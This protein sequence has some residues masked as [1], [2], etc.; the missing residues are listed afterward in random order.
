MVFVSER[1]LAAATETAEQLSLRSGSSESLTQAM[2][3]HLPELLHADLA[4]TMNVNLPFRSIDAFA[5]TPP[6][7]MES[8]D[9]EWVSKI[10]GQHPI[11]RHYASAPR[12]RPRL[13]SDFVDLK[14][15]TSTGIFDEV[16]RRLGTPYQLVIPL[17]LSKRDGTVRLLDLTRAKGDFSVRE[18]DLA[19]VLQGQLIA[20][21]RIAE[22]RGLSTAG[23]PLTSATQLSCDFGLTAREQEVV[24]LL[25]QGRTAVA[26]GHELGVSPRTIGKHL[27]S[28]YSKTGTH[29][30]LAMAKL[31]WTGATGVGRPPH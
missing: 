15:W 8:Q 18:T 2:R 5:R 20:L 16:Y 3:E 14:T 7:R 29:D 24:N 23:T 11:A 21:S 28:I 19:C 27:E 31:L 22:G 12:L 30:R 26:M 10:L 4:A 1:D 25:V 17:G 6:G 13:V 9:Q